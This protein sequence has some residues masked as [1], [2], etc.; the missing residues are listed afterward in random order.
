VGAVP[1]ID[2]PSFAAFKHCDTRSGFE[3]VF[4]RTGETTLSAEGQVGAVEDG[5]PF[6]AEYFIE[7]DRD[8]RT[9]RARVRGRS[10]NGL[11]EIEIEADGAGH[12]GVG[13]AAVSELDGCLDLDLEAS[14]LTNAFP[15]R[16]L[17]LSVGERALAP[18]AWLRA[19]DLRVERLEQEYERVAD[20]DASRERYRYSALE[21]GFGSDLEYDAS[22][23]VVAYPGIATRAA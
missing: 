20:S 1:F 2:P 16:R 10:L 9:R 22:G 21:L 3:V 11:S 7:L 12:W 17:A 14:A 4:F 23:I 13:G 18:A 8:W 5:E 15:I 19:L 6:T